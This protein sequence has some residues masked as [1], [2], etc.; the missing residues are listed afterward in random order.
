MPLLTP[1]TGDDLRNQEDSRQRHW[2]QVGAYVARH[3]QILIALWD[4]N[5]SP[6]SGT[7]RVI[8]WQREGRRAHFAREPDLLDRPER[9]VVHHVTTARASDET[10]AAVVRNILYPGV[11]ST[12]PEVREK[13]KE[14]AEK[15][16]S[17]ILSSLRQYNK[18]TASSRTAFAAQL[19]MSRAWSLPQEK[20]A[21]LPDELASLF[22]HFARADAAAVR[23]QKSSKLTLALLFFLVGAA[24]LCV[25]L[26]AHLATE[27]W[28]LLAAFV[29]LL[30]IAGLAHYW[31]RRQSQQERY[32]DYRALAEA[33][34]VQFFWTMAGLHRGVAD[35]YLRQFRSQLDWI[36]QA[37]RTC[38]LVAGGHGAGS[39][40]LDQ[41]T[42]FDWIAEH[43][44]EGQRQF[45][46]NRQP[47]S[48]TAHERLDLA[49]KV[50][51]WLGVG[52][53]V[54]LLVVHL[55]SGKMNHVLAVFVFL[56]VVF[57]ALLHEWD[58]KSGHAV[59]AQRYQGMQS[60]YSTAKNRMEVLVAAGD[61]A[62]ASE[63]VRKLGQEA[64]SENADWVIQH[65]HRPIGLPN[66]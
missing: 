25:E 36:R 34:R 65:R 59:D 21:R 18:D 33:L 13:E 58:E 41:K 57:A 5:D 46:E 22:E 56:S 27:T 12:N 63:L 30:A 2:E 20:R 40:T 1:I 39:Q 47:R 8:R 43:W 51:F 48:H 66:W 50:C 55:Y 49:E 7:A 52:L 19:D 61:Y 62:Q 32:L 11:E 14:R 6:E 9:G 23:Y 31:S 60:L 16:F 15:H 24:V 35:H 29:A 3:S 4:G 26:Y 44:I 45:F 28:Q 64:L 17:A 53:A 37:V 54:V 10:P 42:R 38:V